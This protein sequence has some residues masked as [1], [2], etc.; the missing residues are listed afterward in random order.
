MI[1]RLIIFLLSLTLLATIKQA[2]EDRIYITVQT[3]PITYPG[4]VKLGLINAGYQVL[5]P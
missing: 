4:G 5:R 2:I 3:M 1:K